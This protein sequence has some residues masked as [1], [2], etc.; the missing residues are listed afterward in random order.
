LGPATFSRKS[1]E[2][3]ITAGVDLFRLNFSHLKQSDATPIIKNIRQASVKLN[4]AIGI[5]IDLQG[6]KIRIGTFS[7]DNINLDQGQYFTLTDRNIP[8]NKHQ[9]FCD[10]PGLYQ[11]VNPKDQIFIDDGRLTLKVISSAKGAVKTRVIVGGMLSAHKGLNIPSAKFSPK[12]LLDQKTIDDVKYGCLQGIDFFALSFVQ[13]AEQVKA[14]KN[15]IA[16]HKGKAKVIAKIE[17]PQAVENIQE[18][19]TAADALMVARGD[20]GIEMSL[21]KVPQIQKNICRLAN[22]YGKPVIIA[23]QMLESM[24]HNPLPTRAEVSD[25]AN[26]IDD[27]ADCLMLSG[28]TAVGDYPLK[29]VRVM[30]DIAGEADEQQTIRKLTLKQRNSYFLNNLNP[31]SRLCNAADQLA[32]ELQAKAIIT[33]TDN[34]KTAGLLSK[35]KASVP[36]IAVTEN[37]HVFQQLTLFRGVYPLLSYKSFDRIKTIEQLVEIT[38]DILLSN[39]LLQ[40]GSLVIILAGTPQSAESSTNMIKLHRITGII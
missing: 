15:L 29:T 10:H 19:I 20:L 12:K 5:I 2:G 35:Y 18:I 1:I 28:E 38:D 16:R 24:T 17:K 23:T 4:K 30:T 34:G 25:V 11:L 32:D 26:A 13:S 14:L 36:V 27:W 7:S 39:K 3:L 40:K 31:V 21:K 8:G 6:P 9:V 37:L 33:Y 22:H